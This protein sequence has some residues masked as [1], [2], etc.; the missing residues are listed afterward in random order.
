LV[1]TV[2]RATPVMPGALHANRSITAGYSSTPGTASIPSGTAHKA[3]LQVAHSRHLA[4]SW[5][6][7]PAAATTARANAA[8][9]AGVPFAGFHAVTYA[10]T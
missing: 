1:R 6:P 9:G 3:S 5:L 2:R 7:G 8:A 4:R 10:D